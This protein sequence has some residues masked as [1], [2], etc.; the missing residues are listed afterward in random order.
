MIPIC[1]YVII[2]T[3]E[4]VTLINQQKQ[5]IMQVDILTHTQDPL[6][7]LY[8]AMRTCYSENNPQDLF[9]CEVSDEKKIKLINK[10]ISSGH[11]STMEH[12]V[13]TFAISGVSRSL[14]AQLTRHRLASYSVQSQRYVD[15]KHFNYVLPS[16]LRDNEQ[17]NELLN[18]TSNLYNKLIDEGVKPEDARALLP[19]AT[20]TN[21]VMTI[22][23]RSLVNF[24]NERLCTNAQG[25]IRE[26]AILMR[27]RAVEVEPSFGEY[28]QPKCEA[29]GYCPDFR[30]CGRKTSKKQLF[31]NPGNKND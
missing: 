6:N 7:I 4:R 17:A 9:D 3:T 25:E 27:N 21:L 13:F 23:L 20:T 19:N 16:K 22:N 31:N 24:C 14:L 10:V 26:L 30:C 11:G 18:T 12:C 5:H 28:L 1:L 2:Y 29:L 8:T 15:G